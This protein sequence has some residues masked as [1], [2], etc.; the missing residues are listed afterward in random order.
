MC[1]HCHLL[2]WGSLWARG[3]C[4]TSLLLSLSHGSVTQSLLSLSP[5]VSILKPPSLLSLSLLQGSRFHPGDAA[6]FMEPHPLRS[7]GCSP[8]VI[9]DSCAE[10][11]VPEQP[12]SVLLRMKNSLFSIPPCLV[13]VD[14]PPSPPGGTWE[15]WRGRVQGPAPASVESGVRERGSASTF[16]NSET[17]LVSGPLSFC[18]EKAA[19]IV[20]LGP[21]LRALRSTV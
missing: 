12:T 10:R 7:Q 3:W 11:W 19:Q 20:P 21:V 9:L 17:W 4:E 8:S 14:G 15:A 16:P 2:M 1:A 5:G 18:C 6:L 13:P